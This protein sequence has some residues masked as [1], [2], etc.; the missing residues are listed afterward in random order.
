MDAVH[1]QPPAVRRSF[2]ANC[3]SGGLLVLTLVITLLL[4]WNIDTLHVEGDIVCGSL[5][6]AGVAIFAE[7]FVR[8]QLH[9]ARIGVHTTATPAKFIY[10]KP[11]RRHWMDPPILVIIYEYF[12]PAGGRWTGS[13]RDA[14]AF[15][16]GF[17]KN[18]FPEIVYD[19][20]EPS[21]HM[22][23]GDMWAVEWRQPTTAI[24]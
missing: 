23:I 3:V 14:T 1:S 22:M 20:A 8:W 12:T 24:N 4:G 16:T 9:L 21:S 6:F 7:L 18:V 19:P 2:A 13:T 11:D 5:P 17:G 15:G 10:E